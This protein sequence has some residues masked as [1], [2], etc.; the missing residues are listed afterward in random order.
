MIGHWDWCI[1]L[2]NVGLFLIDPCFDK[3]GNEATVQT[4]MGD[5]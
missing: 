4:A 3:R 5:R 2:W 1:I